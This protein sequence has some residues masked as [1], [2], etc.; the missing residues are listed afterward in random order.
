MGERAVQVVAWGDPHD[1]AAPI[2]WG[3][4]V[5]GAYSRTGWPTRAQALKAARHLRRALGASHG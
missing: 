1:P 2:I 4:K 3:L 5:D